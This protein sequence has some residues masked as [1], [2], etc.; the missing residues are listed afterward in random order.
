MKNQTTDPWNISRMPG[1][2]KGGS[3]VAVSSGIFRN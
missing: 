3:A 2:S 1:G